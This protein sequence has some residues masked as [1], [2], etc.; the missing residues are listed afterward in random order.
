MLMLSHAL[1]LTSLLALRCSAQ[2]SSFPHAYPGMPTTPFG[3]DWQNYFQ[4]TSSLPNVTDG[5]TRSFAGNVGV[6]RAG[7]PNATLFFWAFEK[8]NG[9]LTGSATTDPWIIWLNGGPGSSSLAGLMLENGPIHVTGT[10]DIVLNNY[11]YSQLA[12]TFWIDQPVGTGY[13]TTD[14]TGYV[15]NEDQ[16]GEDFIGFLSNIVKIFP[17][18][19]TRPLYLLGESYA[20]T[21]IPYITKTIFATPN[22]PVALKKIAVGDGTLGAFP[23]F[24]ELPTLTTIE[25]YPQIINY[26][27]EVYEYFKTQHHLCGY[28]LNLTYPQNGHFP[29]L[30]DPFKESQTQLLLATPSRPMRKSAVDALRSSSLPLDRRELVEREERR[31][32]WKRNI[33]GRANGTLDPWYGCFL[34]EEM[35]DYATNFTFP[36]SNGEVDV[37]SIPDALN[38]EVPQDPSVFLNDART[39]AAIHAPTSKNWV[40]SIPY[41]F[42]AINQST[43]AWGDPSPEPMT[44]L[45]DLA[46]NAS[47]KGVGIMFYSG[48]DDS[49]VAHRG[50]EAVIQNMTFGGV[51]GFTRKPSTPFSDAL[52][53]MAGIIHQERNLTYALFLNAGHLVPQSVPAAAFAFV[54]DFVLGSNTTGLF[55]GSR[56]G[57][58]RSRG[59][60]RTGQCGHILW[61][62]ERGEDDCVDGLAEC[63][64]GV[65]E[66]VYRPGHLDCVC[67]KSRR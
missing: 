42:G 44:F 52:G 19:A 21:Y 32:V 46:T 5:L 62:R 55:N 9:S 4:V 17:S 26:D 1:L 15:P 30:L 38:P 28:D 58:S 66:R 43:N 48:N 34:F 37:Y 24:E 39:R 25:T 18:L 35:W 51:Q 16:M 20:G 13:S 65:V 14:S 56:R 50:T 49:L 2:P 23:V 61:R 59:R 45:S 31:Q 64:C 53:N 54:R 67:G 47:A 10:F 29:T 40:E 22:P 27:P 41:P 12:D 11:S 7:H 3:P 8:S 36:W 6:N 60:C 57:R 63:D 33:A